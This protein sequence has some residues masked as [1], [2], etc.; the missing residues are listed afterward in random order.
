MQFTDIYAGWPGSVHDAR[1][2][3]NSK[4]FLENENLFQQDTHLLGDAAYPAT[5]Y[6]NATYTHF[7]A[8]DRN[9]IQ[10]F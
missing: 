10:D 3:K 2:L 4:V 8:F 9:S 5:R 1:V 6:L 7:T